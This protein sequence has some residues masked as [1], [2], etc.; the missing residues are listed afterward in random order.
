MEDAPA[1]TAR[2]ESLAESDYLFICPIVKGEIL[3]GIVRLDAGPK[4]QNLEQ[5]ANELFAVIPC[6][7]LPE[8][9]AEVYANTKAAA[10]KQGT[11]LGRCD[12][13]I[14]ATALALD[15]ILVT[16]DSDYGRIA[17]LGLRLENWV[18]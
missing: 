8:N 14:A 13:W 7:P 17:D 9:V 5:K 1:I 10:Q 18:N 4:R 15:T 3:F 2:L 12:L 16:S 6:D 11:S